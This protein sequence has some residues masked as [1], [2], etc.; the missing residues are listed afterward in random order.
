M[1]FKLTLTKNV[2]G[3]KKLRDRKIFVNNNSSSGLFLVLGI[4]NLNF[5]IPSILP[6]ISFTSML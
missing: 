6:S 5:V 2:L 4:N 1:L 3:A